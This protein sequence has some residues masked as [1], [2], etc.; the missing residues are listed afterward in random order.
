[1]LPDGRPFRAEIGTRDAN[2]GHRRILDPTIDNADVA[3]ANH[4]NAG[5][6]L[7]DVDDGRIAHSTMCD[8]TITTI[9]M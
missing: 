5:P 3:G 1:M 4:G 9:S 7:P 6:G 8:S 2:A